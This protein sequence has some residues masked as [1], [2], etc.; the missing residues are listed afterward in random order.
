[1]Q[2]IINETFYILFLHTKSSKSS[3]H[4]TLTTYLCSDIKFSLERQEVEKL[5]KQVGIAQV[6]PDR[7][8]SC[9]VTISS[10]S[11]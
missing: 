5:K 10:V 4:F 6:V 2:N 7:L 8:K 1:M 9:L 3:V 11:F